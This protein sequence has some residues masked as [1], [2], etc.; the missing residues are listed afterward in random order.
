[1]DDEQIFE[2][3]PGDELARL[4]KETIEAQSGTPDPAGA[5]TRCQRVID[6]YAK[7]VIQEANDHFHAAWV[8]LCGET[9]AHYELARRFAHRAALLGDDRAWT[10]QAM[11]WDRSLVA[12]GKAQRFGTQIIKQGG[13]WS[14]GVVDPGVKDEERAMYGVPPLFVQQ[15]RAEQLQRQE[16]MRD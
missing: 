7:G 15:Q 6:L 9:Q 14:L 4:A 8:L 10:L 11:A 13:R 5:R 2:E 1:M 12:G 3:S 16:E